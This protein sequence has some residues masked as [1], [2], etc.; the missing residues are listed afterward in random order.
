MT[1]CEHMSVFP[2]RYDERQIGDT[3][4][5]F[6]DQMLPATL[7]AGWTRASDGDINMA[8]KRETGDWVGA[9]YHRK[10]WRDAMHPS[11]KVW[12]AAFGNFELPPWPEDD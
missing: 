7:P 3:V 5:M 6:T 1:K 4:V 12:F 8:W 11:A 9:D 2:R 10:V